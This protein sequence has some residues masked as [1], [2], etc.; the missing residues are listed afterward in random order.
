[1]LVGGVWRKTHEN[2]HGWKSMK[3]EFAM[4]ADTSLYTVRNETF[5]T[6]HFGKRAMKVL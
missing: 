1:M 2:R 5:R 3:V 4:C 6:L